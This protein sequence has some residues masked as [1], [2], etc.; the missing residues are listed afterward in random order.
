MNNIAEQEKK[1]KDKN[2]STTLEEEIKQFAETLPDWSKYLAKRIIDGENLNDEDYGIALNIF[3]QDNGLTKKKDRNEITI[4]KP[5]SEESNFKDDLKLK[6]IENIE[7]VN[8]L[9][10]NQCIDF[11]P[12]V[13]IIYGAN[14]SG[15][16]Y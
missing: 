10:E 6:K 11:S 2:I 12:Q 15:K 3:K 14:G 7:G 8:A 13:T 16:T 9:I 1:I 5:T 4:N